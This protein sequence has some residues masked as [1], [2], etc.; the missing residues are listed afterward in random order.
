VLKNKNQ[1][2]RQGARR[3]GKRSIYQAYVSIGESRATQNG[4]LRRSF[5]AACQ[6]FLL[7]YAQLSN[8]WRCFDRQL[9]SS[10]SQCFFI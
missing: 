10:G 5:S 3:C 8:A 4:G 7:S 2:V 9:I 1:A 6:I